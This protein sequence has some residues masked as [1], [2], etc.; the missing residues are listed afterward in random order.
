MKTPRTRQINIRASEE[1][2]AFWQALS[3][4]TGT[5]ISSLVRM[6]AQIGLGVPSAEEANIR[7]FPEAVAQLSRAGNNLNQLTR[8]ANQGYLVLSDGQAET[9]EATHQAVKSLLDVFAA[10]QSLAQ[11]RDLKARIEDLGR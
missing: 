10:Y 9:I 5:K 6:A 1:E 7:A 2:W 4:E 3:E 8:R 11:R